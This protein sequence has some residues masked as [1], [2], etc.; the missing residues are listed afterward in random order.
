MVALGD[1]SLPIPEGT[2]W[3]FAPAGAAWYRIYHEDRFTPTAIFRR[4]YGPLHRFDHHLPH[5]SAPDIDP[6]GRSVIYIAAAIRTAALEVYGDEPRY[7]VCPRWRI[8]QV[9]PTASVELQD[10]SAESDGG[11]VAIGALPELGAGSSVPREKSQLWARELYATGR[12]GGIRYG[13]AHDL[14]QC[15]VIWDNGP[16]LEVVHDGGVAQ[17]FKIRAPAIWSR[18]I[19]EY[20]PTGRYLDKIKSA[21]CPLCRKAGLASP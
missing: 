16:D 7:E 14:A 20:G 4:T 10:I 21:D 11:A 15:V 8:A 2:T 1:P 6:E 5:I 13:G 12:V 9:R 17:D 3:T 18:V 19:G